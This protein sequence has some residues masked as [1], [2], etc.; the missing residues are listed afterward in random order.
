MRRKYLVFTFPR[1]GEVSLK[2]IKQART[3]REATELAKAS[4][5]DEQLSIV[6]KSNKLLLLINDKLR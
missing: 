1:E 2:F 5:T 6:I 3:K 4:E